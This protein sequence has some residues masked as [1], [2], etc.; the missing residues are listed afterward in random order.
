MNEQLRALER[1]CDKQ[2]ERAINAGHSESEAAKLVVIRL[3]NWI[4]KFK[5]APKLVEFG[6]QLKEAY[7]FDLEAA[8]LEIEAI[9]GIRP[10]GLS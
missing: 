4:E 6:T 1:L 5:H 8:R 9:Y 2:H 7:E 10:V 3:T